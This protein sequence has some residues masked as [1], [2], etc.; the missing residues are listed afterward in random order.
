V[1]PLK[2]REN[3]KPNG[4]IV[5][6]TSQNR[7]WWTGATRPVRFAQSNQIQVEAGKCS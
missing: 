3:L 7:G 6:A 2:R 4:C 5:L 1:V